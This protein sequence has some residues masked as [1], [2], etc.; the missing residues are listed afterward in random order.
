MNPTDIAATL[1]RWTVGGF[2]I[3]HGLAKFGL[4]GGKR[5]FEIQAFNALGLRPGE[6]WS[7]VSGI[8]QIGLGLLL[9]FGFF[10]QVAG[11]AAAAFMVA[12]AVLGLRKNGWYWHVGGMEYAYFWAL[13]ALTVFF[14]GAGPWSLDH[15][16]RTAG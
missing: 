16:L 15:M 11:A 10:T 4:M 8:A 14:L 1:L 2:M 13:A 3:P 12:A 6:V 5:E 9:V 7:I